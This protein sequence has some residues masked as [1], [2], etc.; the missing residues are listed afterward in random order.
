M[1]PKRP[2]TPKQ[3]EIAAA[4][5]QSFK[6]L[7]KSVVIYRP[8]IAAKFGVNAA[9][10]LHQL[11]Y[12][13]VRGADP[14]GWIFK[15]AAEWQTET[16]LTY[17]RQ[18]LVRKKLKAAGVIQEHYQ[19]LSHRMLFRIDI[20][21]FDS[22]FQTTQ[23]EGQFPTLPL[24]S[25]G[26]DLSAVRPP[27]VW[28]GRNTEST[29][30][31]STDTE[32]PPKSSAEAED[33]NSSSL[34]SPPS[35]PPEDTPAPSSP[36][37]GSG[38]TS[39]FPESPHP[40]FPKLTGSTKRDWAAAVKKFDPLAS[41]LIEGQIPGFQWERHPRE[42]KMYYARRKNGSIGQRQVML[43]A[44]Y[45]ASAQ[46][47]EN[48]EWQPRSMGEL[49]ERFSEVNAIIVRHARQ[50]LQDLERRIE[51]LYEVDTDYAL[52]ECTTAK[53]II[54]RA[55]PAELEKLKDSLRTGLRSGLRWPLILALALR[56]ENVELPAEYRDEVMAEIARDSAAMECLRACKIDPVTAFGFSLDDVTARRK[57]ILAPLL[58]DRNR[59]RDWLGLQPAGGDP[60][61]KSPPPAPAVTVPDRL[62]HNQH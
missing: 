2:R 29:S 22:I 47:E 34:K 12:W 14:N 40:D 36:S 52:Q 48:P 62:S 38:A 58:K 7:P 56:G 28:A 33:F 54:D 16:G 49:L 25:S 23:E 50:E 30:T 53:A 61:R 1:K 15:T 60:S 13:A 37:P 9:L 10:F 8:A 31:E 43:L 24:G 11:R 21:V 51:P 5:D 46:C 59:L 18:R 32:I 55:D 26:N 4:L 27:D 45:F 44:A 35:P 20:A 39:E 19:R 3:Q 57:Q 41:A 42:A 6:K 17:K